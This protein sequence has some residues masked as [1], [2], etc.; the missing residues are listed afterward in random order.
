MISTFIFGWGLIVAESKEDN[1]N[2][3]N[4]EILF[5]IFNATHFVELLLLLK[6]LLVSVE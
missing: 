5:L 2:R 4:R 6:I 1:E 3:V